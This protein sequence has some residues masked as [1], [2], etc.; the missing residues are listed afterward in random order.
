MRWAGLLLLLGCARPPLAPPAHAASPEM[1]RLFDRFLGDWTV[2]EEHADSPLTP[3]RGTRREGRARFEPGPGNGSMIE[4]Y[5]AHGPNGDL[6]A[7]VIFSFDPRSGAYQVFKC[8]DDGCDQK[9]VTARWEDDRLVLNWQVEVRGKAFT[10]R[11]TYRDF[12]RD[13]FT[14]VAEAS[15]DGASFERIIVST[16]RRA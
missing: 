8:F 13:S 2:L 7:L 11:D 16:S 15:A 5:H 12:T 14:L 1:Q 3:Q 9:P 6:D 4:R 10:L